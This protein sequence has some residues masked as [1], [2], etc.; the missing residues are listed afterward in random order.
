MPRKNEAGAPIKVAPKAVKPAEETA[1][2]TIAEIFADIDAAWL[3]SLTR[4]PNFTKGGW[5]IED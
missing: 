5:K 1:S 3:K 2:D 4:K